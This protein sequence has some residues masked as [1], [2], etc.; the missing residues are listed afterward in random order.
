[1]LENTRIRLPDRQPQQFFR[2]KPREALV[3]PAEY[4]F[5]IVYLGKVNKKNR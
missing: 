4:Y 3:L 1:M 2:V 5:G